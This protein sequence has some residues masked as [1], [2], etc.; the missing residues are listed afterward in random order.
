[1]FVLA[2]TNEMAAYTCKCSEMISANK[3]QYNIQEP[4][5]TSNKYLRTQ[6]EQ[7]TNQSKIFFLHFVCSSII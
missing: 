4:G 5:N 3:Y 6:S 7:F 1:M 2:I